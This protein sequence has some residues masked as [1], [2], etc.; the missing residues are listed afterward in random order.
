MNPNQKNGVVLLQLIVGLVELLS[1]A[2]VYVTVTAVVDVV[3]LGLELLFLSGDAGGCS[4]DTAHLEFM[5]RLF[6]RKSVILPFFSVSPSVCFTSLG[7]RRFVRGR[8]SGVRSTSACSWDGGRAG[9]E[10]SY[11]LVIPKF[12]KFA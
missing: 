3:G 10:F 1:G 11:F 12:C 6:V 4:F 8:T 2:L 9:N 5:A 7:R